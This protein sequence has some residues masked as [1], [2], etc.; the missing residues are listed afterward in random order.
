MRERVS[1]SHPPQGGLFQLRI[2]D[3]SGA[4]AKEMQSQNLSRSAISTAQYGIE[5]RLETHY[6]FW[7][8]EA[9]AY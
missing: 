2:P 4:A 7:T 9:A 1:S 8:V 6:L 5:S 3:L